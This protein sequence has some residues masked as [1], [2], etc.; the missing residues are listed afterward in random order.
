MAK[1]KKTYTRVVFRVFKHGIDKGEVIA[2]FIDTEKDCYAKG[3]VMSYM[4]VG[5]HC[6]ANYNGIIAETRRATPEEYAPLA[7]ELHR[8]GYTNIEVMYRKSNKNR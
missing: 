2:L 6:E 8:I 7:D 3:N 1:R 4:D 5:Q